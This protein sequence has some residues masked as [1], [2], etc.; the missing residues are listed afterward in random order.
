MFSL[1]I[2]AL[3]LVPPLLIAG[4]VQ[5]PALIWAF[6]AAI[7]YV[8]LFPFFLRWRTKKD[9]RTLSI[10]PLKI[11]TQ[12]GRRSADVPWKKVRSVS[13]TDEHIFIQ[14]SNLNAFTIP[15]RAFSDDKQRAQFIGLCEQY[16]A[17]AKKS[18]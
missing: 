14:R 10:D 4:K 6:A 9:K 12:I 5:F 15:R 3:V 8:L 7:G 16:F 2:A 1:V 13:V 17:A 18:A 11:S